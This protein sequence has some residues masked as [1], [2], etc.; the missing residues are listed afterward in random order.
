MNVYKIVVP[1]LMYGS[2]QWLIN[3]GYDKV[4]LMLPWPFNLFM[5][6]VVRVEGKNHEC[7]Y[8]LE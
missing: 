2:E 7:R 6:K 4:C 1:G 3:E 8:L 5:D